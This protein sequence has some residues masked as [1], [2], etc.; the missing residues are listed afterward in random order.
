L[1]NPA[2]NQQSLL[3]RNTI[4]EIQFQAFGI[5]AFEDQDEE[6]Y[7]R[8]DLSQYD[9]ALETPEE[10][11]SRLRKDKN[12]KKLK[13]A[14][15]S[16][17][18]TL[19]GFVRSKKPAPEKKYFRPPHLPN[20]FQPI[21]LI[22]KS[23][24]ETAADSIPSTSTDSAHKGKQ[25]QGLD[26]HALTIEERQVLLGEAKERIPISKEEQEAKA[27]EELEATQKEQAK[28]K[29]ERLKKFAEVLQAYT[30]NKPNEVDTVGRPAFKPFMK[31]P[32]KQDRYEKYMA[33]VAAGYKGKLQ[34]FFFPSSRNYW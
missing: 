24:F 28:A 26:R 21:H 20:D 25:K 2:T 9:F 30:S 27:K 6:V 3:S 12:A 5:G 33:L 17:S 4:L 11:Q 16:E 29:A 34:L 32:E 1:C 14:E 13:G 18:S 31:N 10:R 23:R 22:R 7:S 19:P 8:D 15:S